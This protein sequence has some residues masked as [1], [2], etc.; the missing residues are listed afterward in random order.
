MLLS[1]DLYSAAVTYLRA[2]NST[3]FNEL[4]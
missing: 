1:A 2:P 4:C 3:D